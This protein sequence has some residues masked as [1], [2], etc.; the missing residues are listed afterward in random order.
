[1]RKEDLFCKVDAHLSDMIRLAASLL[2]VAEPV[3]E[4]QQR[5]EFCTRYL[6]KNGFAVKTGLAGVK[7]AL[8]AEYQSLDGGPVLGFLFG[9]A[10][11]LGGTHTCGHYMQLLANMAAAVALKDAMGGKYPFK[12]VLYSTLDKESCIASE[13]IELLRAGFFHELD[14]ALAMYSGSEMTTA[15]HTPATQSYAVRFRGK[16]A[17]AA[18]HPWDGR[19]AFDGLQLAFHGVE[20]MRKHLLDTAQIQYALT[21]AGGTPANVVPDFAEGRFCVQASESVE[22]GKIRNRLEQILNGAALM[23]GTTVEYSVCSDCKEM[24]PIAPLIRCFYDNVFLAGADLI[25]PPQLEAEPSNL[26]KVMEVVPCLCARIHFLKKGVGSP[27]KICFDREERNEAHEAIV[28]GAKTLAGM[29]CDLIIHPERLCVI[30]DA[31]LKERTASSS[32]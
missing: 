16:Q 19:S 1:M 27:S 9:P 4:V 20:F 13:E 8:R 10:P 24:F 2:A 11:M 3:H 17:H 25:E 22:L 29:G 26:S 12:L 18:A 30:R 7:T 31:W 5:N 32:L 14:I 23:T 6:R 28:A 21:D 15:L